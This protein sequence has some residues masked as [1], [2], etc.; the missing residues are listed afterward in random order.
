MLSSELPN[1]AVWISCCSGFPRPLK[2]QHHTRLVPRGDTN[3]SGEGEHRGAI[4]RLSLNDKG[5]GKGLVQCSLAHS[6]P[7]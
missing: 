4:P 5:S 6:H 3:C 2:G 7:P 1:E